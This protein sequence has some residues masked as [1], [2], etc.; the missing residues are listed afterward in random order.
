MVADWPS[1]AHCGV[2]IG[3]VEGQASMKGFTGCFTPLLITL[4]LAVNVTKWLIVSLGPPTPARKEN[5]KKLDLLYAP[6]R[7]IAIV[8]ICP[9]RTGRL[10]ESSPPMPAR[11]IAI[12]IELIRIRV[13]RVILL[14][15]GLVLI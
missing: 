5:V 9:L 13:G 11:S 1:F 10:C 14:P 2:T 8:I 15:N 7:N 6:I 3:V 4:L 12:L